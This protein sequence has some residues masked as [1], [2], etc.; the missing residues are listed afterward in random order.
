MEPTPEQINE[1]GKKAR[2]VAGLVREHYEALKDTG[3]NDDEAFELAS[4]YHWALVAD[5]DPEDE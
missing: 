5:E 2:R 1:E 4:N 3:F